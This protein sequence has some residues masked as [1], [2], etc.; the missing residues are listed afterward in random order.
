MIHMYVYMYIYISL[1]IYI[2]IY[3][4]IFVF[5]KATK[6]NT[7]QQH[8]NSTYMFR[9]RR[10]PTPTCLRSGI[11]SDPNNSNSNTSNHNNSNTNSNT[12]S[13]YYNDNARGFHRTPDPSL[14]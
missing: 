4:F 7:K 13:K 6:L 14:P 11:L 12:N 10:C 1:S 8:T 2:Y 5:H 9:V 3:I